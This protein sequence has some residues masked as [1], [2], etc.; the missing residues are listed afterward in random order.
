MMASWRLLSLGDFEMKSEEEHLRDLQRAIDGVLIPV[1]WRAVIFGLLCLLG[2]FVLSCATAHVRAI[3]QA[4]HDYPEC[5]A[6]EAGAWDGEVLVRLYC[7]DRA[8][9]VVAYGVY[10]VEVVRK[11]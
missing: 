1:I 5:T 2:L 6:A 8:P 9:F 7:P 10:P 4:A 11:R 3:S